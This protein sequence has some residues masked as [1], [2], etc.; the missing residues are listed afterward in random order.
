MAKKEAA[1]KAVAQDQIRAKSKMSK[2]EKM[3]AK[4]QKAKE[5]AAGGKKGGAAKNAKRWN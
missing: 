2:A 5:F 3:L 1:A 4:K